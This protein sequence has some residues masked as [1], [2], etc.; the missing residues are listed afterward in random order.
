M[1]EESSS[2][3]PISSSTSTLTNE[4]ER[5]RKE[6][7]EL[8]N[9]FSFEKY[10]SKLSDDREDYSIDD[11]EKRF[12]NSIKKLNLPNWL[13]N[14]NSKIPNDKSIHESH[15]KYKNSTKTKENYLSNSTAYLT[16]NRLNNITNSK[17]KYNK[18][19]LKYNQFHNEQESNNSLIENNLISIKDAK[20]F[21][22]K[23]ILNKNNIKN[24]KS[25]VHL[26]L[27][28]A[29]KIRML[30]DEIVSSVNNL[31]NQ[32]YDNDE[33]LNQSKSNDNFNEKCNLSF[34]YERSSPLDLIIKRSYS[35]YSNFNKSDIH[36]NV[37]SIS[38]SN[39]SLCYLNKSLWNK[40]NKNSWYKPKNL[41]LP[42]AIP[43]YD[44]TINNNKTL[45]S[46]LKIEQTLLNY[47]K[48]FMIILI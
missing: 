30:N 8:K 29:N 33:K 25:L 24:S 14:S 11:Y 6:I 22:R 15:F 40:S 34:S 41:Q 9:Q 46:N 27:D 45:S 43:S 5:N 36:S 18:I 7:F 23:I 37:R 10:L 44:S 13:L 42:N 2:F 3:I 48:Y 20:D 12:L 1:N 28:T 21:K 17:Y 16:S 26:S 4:V 38:K 35:S 47:G 32:S 31:N 39:Y 19:K